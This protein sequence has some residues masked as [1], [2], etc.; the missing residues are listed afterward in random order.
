MLINPSV[1]NRCGSTM[2]SIG[3][4]ELIWNCSKLGRV[5]CVTNV[6]AIKPIWWYLNDFQS[7]GLNGI[8]L[9]YWRLF[10]DGSLRLFLSLLHRDSL[11]I[12]WVF[13]KIVP[14]I[15]SLK[16]RALLKTFHEKAFHEKAPVNRWK[17]V[18][19]GPITESILFELWQKLKGRRSMPQVPTCRQE[20][21]WIDR[22][23]GMAGTEYSRP[24]NRIDHRDVGDFSNRNPTDFLELKITFFESQ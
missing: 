10:L 2:R 3:S 18:Y 4:P 13:R 19:Y 12:L 20:H 9:H 17:E 24:N 6:Q 16:Y 21:R 23:N 14:I 15:G 5:E 7:N 22:S 8:S 1:I 11:D